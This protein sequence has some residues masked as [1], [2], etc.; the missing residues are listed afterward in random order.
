MSKVVHVSFKRDR[1]GERDY[2]F[3]SVAA[4]FDNFTEVDIGCKLQNL[5]NHGLGKGITYANKRCTVKCKEI[6][7]KETKRGRRS[8]HKS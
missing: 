1:Q 5:Y 7:K 8:I 3:D 4:I 6:I 2:Y